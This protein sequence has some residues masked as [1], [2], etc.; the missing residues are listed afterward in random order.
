M[1]R[2]NKRDAVY[3]EEA[4]DDAQ[5]EEALRCGWVSSARQGELL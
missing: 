2:Q 1:T 5:L 4:D 3:L